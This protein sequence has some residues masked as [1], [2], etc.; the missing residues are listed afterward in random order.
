M[1]DISHKCSRV[2]SRKLVICLSCLLISFD[3]KPLIQKLKIFNV[4]DLLLEV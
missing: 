1:L 2:D 3:N 4:F